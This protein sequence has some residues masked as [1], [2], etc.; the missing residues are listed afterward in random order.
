MIEYK[1]QLSRIDSRWAMSRVKETGIAVRDL[2]WLEKIWYFFRMRRHD[3]IY[4]N[5]KKMCD[6]ARK[7]IKEDVV[8]A[9]SG[10]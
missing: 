7:P 5:W 10:L 1:W 9:A 8:K 3:M 2:C 4:P 6:W